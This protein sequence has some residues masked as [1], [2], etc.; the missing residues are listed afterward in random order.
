MELN[1]KERIVLLN[2]LPRQGDMATVRIVRDLQNSLAPSEDEF[3]EFEIKQ[4][5]TQYSWNEKGMA[6]KEIKIGARARQIVVDALTTMD[7]AKQLTADHLS[8]Y[9]KFVEAKHDSDS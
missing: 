1:L 8:V 9:E 6:P 5:G 2:V 7:K 4:E 3:K